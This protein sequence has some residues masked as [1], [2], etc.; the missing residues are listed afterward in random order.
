MKLHFHSLKLTCR[1][2][3]ELVSFARN[4]TFFHGTLSSGKSSIAR[5]IGF[6][7]G[8]DLEQTTA[9]RRELISVQ[10]SL[11]IEEYQVLLERNRDENQVRATWIDSKSI[12]STVL[13]RAKGDGPPVIGSHIAN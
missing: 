1:H 4:V 2:S 8:G 10:L 12:T 11:A 7:L 5:L 6:C 9:L 13:V 3:E